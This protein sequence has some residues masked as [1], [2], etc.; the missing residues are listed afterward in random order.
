MGF[1]DF[2]GTWMGATAPDWIT[3]T[4][5]ERLVSGFWTDAD[6][7]ADPPNAISLNKSLWW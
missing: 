6:G 3:A 4:P 7:Y 5:A 1:G 2:V